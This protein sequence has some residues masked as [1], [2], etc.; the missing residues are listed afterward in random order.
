MNFSN[1][2]LDGTSAVG[3][4]ETQELRMF[5]GE[6]RNLPP[7]PGPAS[8]SCYAEGLFSA[9]C[10][11]MCEFS[12]L[13]TVPMA[14]PPWLGWEAWGRP[15]LCYIVG[16]RL[17]WLQATVPPNHQAE[18]PHDLSL[19]TPEE[20]FFSLLSPSSF[21]FCIPFFPLLSLLPF[22]PVSLFPSLPRELLVGNQ[23][24]V[25]KVLDGDFWFMPGPVGQACQLAARMRPTTNIFKAQPI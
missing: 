5:S 15:Q 24:T 6:N 7:G 12:C 9:E 10:E 14:R 25:R 4:S 2:C 1:D 3:I 21:L 22:L 18:M 20:H 17:V 8:P 11:K 16:S 19:H 13:T 23:M